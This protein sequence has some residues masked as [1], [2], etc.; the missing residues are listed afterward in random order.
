MSKGVQR[1]VVRIPSFLHIT[2]HCIIGIKTWFVSIP[3][4]NAL[5][6]LSIYGAGPT[7]LQLST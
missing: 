2:E 1:H 5:T 4:G 7:Q 6:G 3:T